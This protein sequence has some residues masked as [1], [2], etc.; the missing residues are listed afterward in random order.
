MLGWVNLPTKSYPG[1]ALSAMCFTARWMHEARLR[2]AQI[3]GQRSE[4]TFQLAFITA[5]TAGPLNPVMWQ[6]DKSLPP[7]GNGGL[8]WPVE[9]MRRG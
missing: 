9:P 4:K 5:T 8:K 7:V 2:S 6:R 1:C 3:A